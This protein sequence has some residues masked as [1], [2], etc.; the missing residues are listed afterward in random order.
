MYI[1]EYKYGYK[2]KNIKKFHN[3]NWRSHM[4]WIHF[5]TNKDFEEIVNMSLILWDFSRW[6]SAE[7]SETFKSKF[8]I[9][10]RQRSTTLQQSLFSPGSIISCSTICIHQDTKVIFTMSNN[11]SCV[12]E[13]LLIKSYHFNGCAIVP[14]SCQ[15]T[16]SN[17]S[18]EFQIV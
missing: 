17:L 13:N 11:R 8:E 18:V 9:F 3:C 16:G 12:Q 5:L 1:L 7:S 14:P 2:C 10:V 6:K 15:K 4:F